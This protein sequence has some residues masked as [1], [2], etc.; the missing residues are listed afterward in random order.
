MVTKLE[1]CSLYIVSFFKH[2]YYAQQSSGLGIFTPM[3]NTLSNLVSLLGAT[4]IGSPVLVLT[5][6][7]LLDQHSP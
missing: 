6:P 5:D 7:L 4:V 2:P 1:L 3:W